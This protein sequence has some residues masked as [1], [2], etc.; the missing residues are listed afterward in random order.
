M[1]MRNI[2]KLQNNGFLS[3]QQAMTAARFAE[4]PSAFHLAPS[5][6]RIL[7]ELI[8]KDVP[9]EKFEE[10]RCW[11]ARSAKLMLSQLLIAMDETFIAYVEEPNEDH[12]PDRELIEEQQ[13]MIKFLTGDDPS[14]ICGLMKD[15]DFTP[16]EAK[17]FF[18]LRSCLDR[19]VRKET[20]IR[21]M[22]HGRSLDEYPETK[23][24]DVFVCKMRKKLG[25]K[26]EIQT[27]WGEGYR[28]VS[29]EPYEMKEV[30]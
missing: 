22:Y 23:I 28:L 5:F 1:S 26:Y 7:D 30:A 29:K 24:V 19:T 16:K 21:R 13:E 14:G 27:V 9:I 8:L 25:G 15:F 10:V 4:N 2:Q 11:P 20:I 6:M 3:D 12:L 17:M 18:I